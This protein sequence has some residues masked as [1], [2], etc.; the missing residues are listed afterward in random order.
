M[1]LALSTAATADWFSSAAA[2]YYLMGFGY[3]EN[4]VFAREIMRRIRPRARVYIINVDDFFVQ[5][6]TAPVR[7]VMRDS[8][9][10]IHYEVKRA[11]QMFHEWFCR[12]FAAAC[13]DN[14]VIFRSRETGAYR[15][16]GLGQF[17]SRAISY[18]SNIDRSAVEDEVA[19]G[20][21]FLSRLP[22]K[23]ECIILT[24]VPS[25]GTKIETANAVAAALGM[26]LVA[27][28]VDGLR[29]FDGSHL[30]RPSAERWSAAFLHA[31]SPRIRECIGES[32]E[33]GR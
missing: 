23:P 16:W 13:G 19:T 26:N 15:V 3:T 31:A 17:E 6:E 25:L 12:G 24:M 10:R 5:S 18:D 32:R 2:S 4:V 8:A 20:K 7:T 29:T 28:A 9:A 33:S 27:P 14:Y 21:E 22:V 30:D 1:Q 11:W